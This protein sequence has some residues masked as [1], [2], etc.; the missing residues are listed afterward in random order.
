MKHS[1]Y[2]NA[3]EQWQQKAAC[4]MKQKIMKSGSKIYTSP[5]SEF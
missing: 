3:Q 1:E 2:F 4:K 5:D